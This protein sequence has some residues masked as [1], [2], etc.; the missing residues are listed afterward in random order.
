MQWP[1]KTT[2]RFQ[3]VE[4]TESRLHYW[5][6][7]TNSAEAERALKERL[8]S[9]EVFGYRVADVRPATKDEAEWVNLPPNCVMLLA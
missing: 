8:L 4:G 6:S 5:V 9:N 2:V 3:G 1:Y 7:A